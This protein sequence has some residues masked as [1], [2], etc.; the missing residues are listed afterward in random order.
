VPGLL[1]DGPAEALVDEVCALHRAH[2]DR[3]A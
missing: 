1:V 3:S 2:A